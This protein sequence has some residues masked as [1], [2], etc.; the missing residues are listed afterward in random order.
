MPGVTQTLAPLIGAVAVLTMLTGAIGA[1]AQAD[2][3]RTLGYWVISGIGIMLAGIAIGNVQAISAVIFYAF[4]S[5]V[6]MTALYFMAGLAAQRAGGFA[7]GALGGLWSSSPLLSAIAL[8]LFFSVAGLQL[9]WAMHGH[10]LMPFVKDPETA[11]SFNAL[12]TN[13][14]NK[15]G[16]DTNTIP[17]EFPKKEQS[18]VPWWVALRNGEMKYIR[19]LV[20]G[21]VE[22][23][24]DLSN[25]P[26]ELKNLA[27]DPAHRDTAAAMRKSLEA[28][29]KRTRCGFADRLP[30]VAMTLPAEKR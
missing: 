17:K 25:D 10:D 1:I 20:A 13:T 12:F 22:E 5:M 6:V 27:Y 30:P 23:L 4:H 18:G 11:R 29:L 3:R 21:E 28:E 9:P 2:L 8:A 15:F 19:T 24:Y 26:D 16:S 7:Q 14:G